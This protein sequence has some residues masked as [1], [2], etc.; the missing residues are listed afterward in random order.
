MHLQ[1]KAEQINIGTVVGVLVER[2]KNLYNKKFYIHTPKYD[3]LYW[4]ISKLRNLNAFDKIN[5]FQ[6]DASA[7]TLLTFWTRNKHKTFIE[8]SINE[9]ISETEVR[10][11]SFDRVHVDTITTKYAYSDF[12]NKEGKLLG[13][14]DLIEIIKSDDWEEY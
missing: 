14:A 1:R 5:H 10:K 12:Y 11:L 4:C 9:V 6:E 13:L 2:N 8:V 7:S 3:S